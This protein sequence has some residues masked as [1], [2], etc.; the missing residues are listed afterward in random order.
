[1][2]HHLS[3]CAKNMLPTMQF[4]PNILGILNIGIKK[5]VAIGINDDG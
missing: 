1:M 5:Q 3:W 2:H 4:V